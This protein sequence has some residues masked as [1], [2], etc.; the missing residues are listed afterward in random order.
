MTDAAA[1]VAAVVVAYNRADLLRESLEAIRDQTLPPVGIVVVDNA[2]TDATGQVAASFAPLASVTTLARNTGGAGGFAVGIATALETLD[3]DY[4]WIMDDDSIPTPT[5]LAELV[6][7]VQA[8][9]AA[10]GAS[11]VVWHDGRDH[12]MN[13]PRERPFASSARKERASSA[14]AMTVRSASFVSLLVSTEAVRAEGLP[15]VDYFIWNDDFEYSTR[16]LRHRDG[17]YVPASVVVHKTAKFGATDVD[18]G[19]R[20]YYEVRNK[21]WMLRR[22]RSLSAGEKC[23]YGASTMRRWIRTIRASE[24]RDVLRAAFSRGWRD[25]WRTD[26]QPNADALADLGSVAD[27]VRA[28]EPTGRP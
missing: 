6:A 25:G 9:G 21:L 13:T 14:S 8:A 19:E 22:S 11:R 27:T 23:L 17:V 5:A 12:P 1:R 15:V 24:R 28:A 26:P 10:L 16:I 7:G 20:F 4:V 3:A 18:P 2:S